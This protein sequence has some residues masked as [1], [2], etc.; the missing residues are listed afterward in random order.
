M[1]VLFVDTETTGV[2]FAKDHV[3]EI[4]AI[5]YD[6]D[7]LTLK[8]QLVSSFHSTVALRK[9]LDERITRITGISTEELSTAKPIIKVQEQWCDWL[10]RYSS[11]LQAII[12][13]SI[14]FDISFLQR[15]GWFLP[16]ISHVDTLDL[17]KILLPDLQAINLEFLSKKL[18]LA[19]SFESL[20]LGVGHEF[21][22]H[23]SIFD[24]AMCAG[25]FE[26]LLHRLN[27]FSL[28]QQFYTQL[29]QYFLPLALIWYGKINSEIVS[30]SSTIA[31]TNLDNSKTEQVD[32][33][34]LSSHPSKYSTNESLREVDFNGQSLPISV[35][36]QLEFL[37]RNSREIINELLELKW[38][39]D[40]CLVV[41]Q[42]CVLNNLKLV[43]TT[44]VRQKQNLKLHGQGYNQTARIILIYLFDSNFR[45]TQNSEITID[46]KALPI[47]KTS[48]ETSNPH[49][50]STSVLDPNTIILHYETI[51]EKMSL[52][53]DFNWQ[54][55]NLIDL[56]ELY[57]SLLGA[58]QQPSQV[59]QDIISQYDFLIYAFQ[60]FILNGNLTLDFANLG[61]KENVVVQK[62]KRFIDAVQNTSL[63]KSGIPNMDSLLSFI[64]SKIREFSSEI[65]FRPKQHKFRIHSKNLIIKTTKPNFNLHNHLQ[66]VVDETGTVQTN[67][68]LQNF[69]ILVQLLKINLVG[70]LQHATEDYEFE[71]SSKI[72][73]EQFLRSKIEQS[74]VS[75]KPILILCGLNSSINTL[76]KIC[77]NHNL[78]SDVLIIG[79]SGG[80]TKIMSKVD[81]GFVGIVIIKFSALDFILKLNKHYSLP[82]FD[83]VVL[84]DRPYFEIHHFWYQQ[85]KLSSNTEQYLLQLKNLYLRGKVNLINNCLNCPVEFVFNLT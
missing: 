73:G 31:N 21:S 52:V 62:L 67:L 7:P 37:D 55:G 41:L 61:H 36:D 64:D 48:T 27:T 32:S 2:D 25:L 44:L 58:N 81:Q 47:E 17:A 10:E 5:V 78:M 70:K 19:D 80:I 9:T 84:F 14:D 45:L 40:S 74:K 57:Q 8:L 13:H 12:G 65:I 23:R 22:F 43:E 49:I 30:E 35:S 34:I 51:I 68:T 77:M 1:L 83:Q 76:E 24:C 75:Q 29:Q 69:D 50:H 39:K 56:L 11:N 72:D 3:I 79:E 26:Q 28:P 60:P 82:Q 4:G 63:P 66:K 38:N 53:M 15:E 18:E 6:L 85:A 71:S 20:K 33:K 16:H 54:L 46:S 42:L 59:L